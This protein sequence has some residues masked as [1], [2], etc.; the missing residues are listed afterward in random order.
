MFSV[1]C[2]VHTLR[3]IGFAFATIPLRVRPH[4]AYLVSQLGGQH[5]FAYNHRFDQFH[6]QFRGVDADEM[7]N[8][9]PR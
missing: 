8:S 1:L 5:L 3:R 6:Q 7:L 4:G 2:L 9:W